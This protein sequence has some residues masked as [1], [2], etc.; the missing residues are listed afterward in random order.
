MKKI[1]GVNGSPRK[2]GNTAELLTSF[3]KGVEDAG[4]AEVTLINLI[5]YNFTGCRSCF[6]CKLKGT[7]YG[8]C[9]LHDDISEL[10]KEI[11]HGDGIVI[12]SPIYFGDVS[13]LL[14]NFLERLLFPFN[15]YEKGW[16]KIAPKRLAC[17]CIYTMMVD[18]LMME[19][20]GYAQSLQCLEKA[21][22]EIF[23]EPDILYCFE[24][25]HR[26]AYEKYNIS[27]FSISDREYR[28]ETFELDKQAAYENGNEMNQ[29]LHRKT[30]SRTE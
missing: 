4:D 23:T 17:T 13:G 20:K 24:T 26:I 5:D 14:H 11:S 2:N 19:K 8:T 30:T 18:K 9:V 12:A 28:R 6:S 15:S 3:L 1:Y 16:K 25:H 21:I 7:Q 27:A 29:R 10:L 22:G